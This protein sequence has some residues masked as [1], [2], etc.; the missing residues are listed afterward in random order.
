M[1]TVCSSVAWVSSAR[2]SEIVRFGRRISSLN[3]A[4]PATLLMPK[5]WTVIVFGPSAAIMSRSDWSKPRIIAV[6]PTIEVMPI[7]TPST[8]RNERILLPR[9]VSNAITTTSLTRPI[10]I[11]IT[12][13]FPSQRLD[14]VERGGLHRR[15]DP[16]EQADQRGN[17]DAEAD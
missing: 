9:T 5:R 11:A 3:S 8:V 13:S 7:T 10:R 17:G 12:S 16:E 15:V 2:A 1:S 14:R 6:M 4:P